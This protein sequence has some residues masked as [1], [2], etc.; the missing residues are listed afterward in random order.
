MKIRFWFLSR[1]HGTQENTCR[2]CGQDL[3]TCNSCDGAWRSQACSCGIGFYCPTHRR[4][5]S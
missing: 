5:W 2:A 4:Y 3:M 1:R